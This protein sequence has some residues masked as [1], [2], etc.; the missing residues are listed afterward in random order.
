MERRC[1]R[2]CTVQK[3]DGDIDEPRLTTACVEKLD[4][5]AEADRLIGLRQLRVWRGGDAD[6]C[7]LAGDRIAPSIPDDMPMRRLRKA[8]RDIKSKRRAKD[9]VGR[10][11]LA[12][13]RT[14]SDA[15]LNRKVSGSCQHARDGVPA[16]SMILDL[17]RRLRRLRGRYC[18][19]CWYRTGRRRYFDIPNNAASA[20][21][22]AKL[23]VRTKLKAILRAAHRSWQLSAEDA[24]VVR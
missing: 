4:G 18:S 19:G 10:D 1:R 14:P 17:H 24:A 15:N 7:W 22:I 9:R 2:P 6:D 3:L 20:E 8:R 23:I 21:Q 12:S 11:L 16:V 13:R 5:G